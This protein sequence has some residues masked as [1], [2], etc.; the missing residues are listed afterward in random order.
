MFRDALKTKETQDFVKKYKEM[1][2][3]KKIVLGVDRTDYIKG[4]PQR[5]KSIERFLEKQKDKVEE[6]VFLQVAIP[7][8]IS[9]KEYSAYVEQINKQ[10]EQVNSKY[11]SI[12]YTPIQ[13]IFN[14]VSFEELCALYSV[15]DAILI[16]SVMDGMNLVAMEYIAC[17]DEKC[18]SVILSE[19]TGATCTLIGSIFHN[20]NSTEEIADALVV[21]LNLSEEE[22][23]KNH[24]M[25]RN[26]IDKFTSMGWAA[27]SLDRVCPEW[28]ENIIIK[29]EDK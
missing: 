2:K 4:I 5:F 7:S 3:G 15:A 19:F 12:S 6:Y 25:N 28:K 13:M 23:K 29:K 22:R 17:Q 27:Q 8:R 21:G 26:A 1:Y 18:G 10:I 14:S 24:E 11:G 20:A 9:V 16:T